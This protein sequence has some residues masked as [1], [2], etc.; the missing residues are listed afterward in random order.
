V[1]ECSAQ[2]AQAAGA[3]CAHLCKV[4]TCAPALRELYD[5]L[6]ERLLRDVQVVLQLCTHGSL[7]DHARA[8]L[9]GTAAALRHEGALPVVIFDTRDRCCSCAVAERAI[10]VGAHM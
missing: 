2:L 3:T 8:G 10:A 6:G 4:A 7:S 1:H 9:P 5:E